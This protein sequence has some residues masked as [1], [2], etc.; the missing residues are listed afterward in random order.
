MASRTTR[1]SALALSVALLAALAPLRAGAA[2]DLPI[3]PGAEVSSAAGFCTLNF[4][5][6][7]AHGRRYIG[8]AGHCVDGVGDRVSTADTGEFGTVVYRI[9]DDDDD[10]SLIR[11]DA[12]KRGKVNPEVRAFGLPVGYARAS[13]AQ[14]GDLLQLT[15][16]GLGFSINAATRTRPGILMSQDSHQYFAEL[17][18]IFGDSGG[19]VVNVSTGQALG[20]VSG[21][22]PTI[23]PSTLYGSTVERVL[24]LLHSSGFRAVRLLTR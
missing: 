6:A 4:V 12:N 14:A 24:K 5:F 3:Q 21:I 23:P 1:R 9:L 8:T 11:I 18:A 17:P 19:P 22:A 7:G 20:V 2:A 13:E 15:G 10:F 16:Y